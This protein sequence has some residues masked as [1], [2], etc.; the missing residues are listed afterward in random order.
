MV[1]RVEAMSATDPK[2]F[3]A[4]HQRVAAG[5]PSSE[6]FKEKLDPRL[7]R[8]AVGATLVTLGVISLARP[9]IDSVASVD[10]LAHP[11]YSPAPAALSA[12]PALTIASC[13]P[14]TEQV[15]PTVTQMAET[16]RTKTEPTKP[17]A[18][19]TEIVEP[20]PS[21]AYAAPDLEK[22]E[23]ESFK[24]LWEF[25]REQ[26][27]ADCILA[28]RP[29]WVTAGRGTTLVDIAN[30]QYVDPDELRRANKEISFNEPLQYGTKV[31]VTC[32]DGLDLNKKAIFRGYVG[33]AKETNGTIVVVKEGQTLKEI[34]RSEG[35]S[36]EDIMRQN[37]MDTDYLM[38]NAILVVPGR[39]K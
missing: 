29:E 28:G 24:D 2:I 3:A 9:T 27:K 5:S 19:P 15:K 4:R 36:V 6:S 11:T 32:P 39:K 16:T 7:A 37:Q 34:A 21:P 13:P 22:T 14:P 33:E 18:T 31:L 17:V 23:R 26:T 20:E 30:T 38:P 8:F 12:E 35:V 25:L 1:A 10:V